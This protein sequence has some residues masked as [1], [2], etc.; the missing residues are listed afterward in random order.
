LLLWV[1]DLAAAPQASLDFFARLPRSAPVIFVGS[2]LDLVP[3]S[4]LEKIAPALPARRP[5]LP[6]S[7]RTGAHIDRL[8]ALIGQHLA[9]DLYDAAGGGLALTVR[10]HQ[11]LTAAGAALALARRLLAPGGPLQ[12]ELLALELRECLDHLGQISGALASDDILG[13]IFAQFCIGK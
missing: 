12:L 7:A 10:Q 13:R 1:I 4:P 2:K 6:V 11:A 9:G 5:F 3:G 8:R